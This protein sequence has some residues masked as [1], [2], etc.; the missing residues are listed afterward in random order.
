MRDNMREEDWNAIRFEV[1][2]LSTKQARQL[3][4]V[5]EDVQ[6]RKSELLVR[7]KKIREEEM[8]HAAEA[9]KKEERRRL[10]AEKERAGPGE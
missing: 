8:R 3:Q 9:H 1:L 7:E 2:H 10:E 6:R 5:L 4:K